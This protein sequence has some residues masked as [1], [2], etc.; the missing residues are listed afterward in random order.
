[1]VEKL[2]VEEVL[3]N[4]VVVGCYVLLKVIWLLLVKIFVGVGGEIQLIDVI[5]EFMKIEVVEVFYMSGCVYDCGD[6]LGY[7][8]VIIEYGICDEKLGG[9]F[10]EF[11]NDIVVFKV[12]YLKVV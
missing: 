1:M 2:K 9:E 6:K 8:K 12:S 3:F 11:L 10:F 4:L 5:D 7:L